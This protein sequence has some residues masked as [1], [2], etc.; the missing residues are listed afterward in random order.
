MTSPSSTTRTGAACAT[1]L[2]LA[3]TLVAPA[4]AHVAPSVD[5][6]NRYLKVTPSGDRV[7][8]AYTILF[9][10][11][12]GAQMRRSLDANRDGSIDDAE[13]NAFGTKLAAEVLAGLEASVDG[14][15]QKLAWTKVLVGMGT[16]NVVAGTFSVDLVA[17]L[18]LPSVGGRHEVRIF[19]RFRLSKPGETELKVE[20]GPGVKIERARI[21]VANDAG[22]AYRFVG[23]GGPLADDGLDLAFVA[24]DKAPTGGEGGCSAAAGRRA[25]PTGLVVGSAAIL[26]FVLA[27]AV[28]VLRRR[29][30]R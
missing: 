3:I 1:L 5:D 10:E 26:G 2:V 9:G 6:N 15:P 29:R 23:P 7:R 8:V 24:T 20:D 13:A 4:A 11:V 12:P 30:A 21:G 22:W 27:V 17:Y 14:A 19:D 28:V 25:L 16:P 18:C